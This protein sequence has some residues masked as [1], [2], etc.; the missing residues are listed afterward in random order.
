MN[1]L[2]DTILSEEQIAETFKLHRTM[3]NYAKKQI[4]DVLSTQTPKW[5]VDM[6]KNFKAKIDRKNEQETD[7]CPFIELDIL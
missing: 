2:S 7:F 4:N 3:T 6:I 5:A 1:Y